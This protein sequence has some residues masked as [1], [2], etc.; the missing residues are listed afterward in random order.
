ML[1]GCSTREQQQQSCCIHTPFL[2]NKTRQT[3]WS[4]SH[5]K[6]EKNIKK[7]FKKR[8][9]TE[10]IS[11]FVISFPLR[12][13]SITILFLPSVSKKHNVPGGSWFFS[14]PSFDVVKSNYPPRPRDLCWTGK[15]F[16]ERTNMI[17]WLFEGSDESDAD[18]YLKR[19]WFFYK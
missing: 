13:V 5:K 7:L 17:Y 19:F 16:S 18:S 11:D 12:L 14:D 4:I 1:P 3:K 10:I 9:I 6:S 15:T 2:S 8:C